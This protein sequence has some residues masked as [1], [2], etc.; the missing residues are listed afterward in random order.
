MKKHLEIYAQLQAEDKAQGKPPRPIPLKSKHLIGKADDFHC[1]EL[2]IQDLHALF[3]PND[4]NTLREDL[5]DFCQKMDL[6]FERFDY[7]PT[8]IH[9]QNGPPA[10][11]K[12]LFIPY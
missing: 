6:H 9:I 8:W 7:T 12:R 10:S 1:K 11:G 3:C 2:S 4:L 5:E